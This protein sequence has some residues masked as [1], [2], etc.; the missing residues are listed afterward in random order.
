MRV[1]PK[2]VAYVD[3][4]MLLRDCKSTPLFVDSLQP[5]G[6]KRDPADCPAAALLEQEKAN[7][8]QSLVDKYTAKYREAERLL[9]GETIAGSARVEAEMEL[10]C[11]IVSDLGGSLLAKVGDHNPL[12]D[13]E[14]TE[15][16]LL[17]R[18]HPGACE[19]N[20]DR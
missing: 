17:G 1:M 12:Y 19:I 16:C 4:W 7:P 9:P 6:H 20:G 2:V 15:G 14:T 8:S 11:E 5:D 18:D 3:G 13:C 10:L